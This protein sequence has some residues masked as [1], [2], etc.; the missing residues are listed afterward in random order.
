MKESGNHRAN[1]APF[2]RRP[3][4]PLGH[5]KPPGS[6]RKPGVPN[7]TTAEIRAIAQKY[8]RKAIHTLVKLAKESTDETI[9]LKAIVEILDRGYGRPVTPSEVQIQSKDI[10]RVER[11]IVIPDQPTAETSQL[12]PHNESKEQ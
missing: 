10:G 3:G 5:P 1:I 8:G 2:Q 11:I 12:K 9:K 4:K 7:K 6:G